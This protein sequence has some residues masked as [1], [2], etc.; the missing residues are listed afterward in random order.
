MDLLRKDQ[1]IIWHPFTSLQAPPPIPIVSA[2]GVWLHTSDGRQILDAVSSWWVNLYGHAH[3]V[4]AEA[5][6]KQAK[7]LEHVIFAGFTHEPAI[8]VAEKLL[9]LCGPTFS[10]VFFS[11]N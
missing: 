7:S 6:A 4:I 2:E 8:L 9:K 1:E 11:D 10:K 3:P 5:I